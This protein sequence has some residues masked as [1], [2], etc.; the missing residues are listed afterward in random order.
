M[1]PA[2]SPLASG[3]R[4]A[5]SLS[6]GPSPRGH[7]IY[8]PRAASRRVILPRRAWGSS[9]LWCSAR[10]CLGSRCGSLGRRHAIRAWDISFFLETWAVHRHW[11]RWCW[12]CAHR[13][14]VHTE[15][16]TSTTELLRA[17]MVG[18]Y[19]I[20]AFN[21]YNLEGVRAVVNA[22]EAQR[23]PVML[24]LHPGALQ[25]GGQPLVAL[26]LAAAQAA[27]VPVM[28]HLDHSPAPAAIQA[29]LAA[30]VTSVMADGSHLS[31][32]DN[33]TFTRTMVALAHDRQAVVEAELGRLTG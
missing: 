29:A 2:P 7:A 4:P 13:R 17:A 19:A 9:G 32:E 14:G 28:V 10:S 22:A 11:P 3:C 6:S 8:W 20:G 21:V 31:Y 16:L 12:G 5:L 26:C 33:V 18:E 25:H 23:S 1:R 27:T 15:M 24:Q 30:G